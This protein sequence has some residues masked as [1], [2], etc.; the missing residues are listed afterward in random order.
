[1]PKREEKKVPVA[2]ETAIR[3]ALRSKRMI[4]FRCLSSTMCMIVSVFFMSI[5]TAVTRSEISME[6]ENR[7][8]Q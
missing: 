1:M 6:D 2:I 8:V 7:R 3:L 5:E 4:L